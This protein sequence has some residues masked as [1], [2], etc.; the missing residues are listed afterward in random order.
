VLILDEPTNDLDIE[1]L[2]LLESLLQNY[3]GTLFLVSHDREFLD[4][5]VTQVIAFEGNGILREYVG[6]YEDWVRAKGY[7]KAAAKEQ[8]A[9]SQQI[10]P[11]KAREVREQPTRIKL[12]YKE[13]RE[14]DELPQKIEL[15]EREQAAITCQLDTADF[16]L[17]QPEKARSLHERFAKIEEELM[18]CLAR[19]EELEAKR[20]VNGQKS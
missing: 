12:D 16:Y 1:T 15:L 2:E 4:N 9:K 13:I 5:V 14:L 20:R 3:S 11:S 6:G 10:A 7:L 17:N 19:W 18:N 8:A